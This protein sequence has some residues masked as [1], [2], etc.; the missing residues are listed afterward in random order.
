MNYVLFD[1]QHHQKL[2]PLTLTRP[3]ADLRVGIFKIQD[4]WRKILDQEVGVRCKDY[5]ASKFNSN[6]GEV[7]YG[8]SGSLCPNE[9]LCEAIHSLKDKTIMM[10]DLDDRFGCILL[11]WC[12]MV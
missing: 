10:E 12:F 8:I 5:L 7:L 11:I 6:S 2:K 1:G 3:V 9:E 4:K